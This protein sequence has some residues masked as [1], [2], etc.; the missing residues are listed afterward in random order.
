MK[1]VILGFILGMPFW[2]SSQTIQNVNK[3]NGTSAP[4]NISA[5]D[6]IVFPAGGGQ[7]QIHL[8]NAAPVIHQ[9]QD[10]VNVNFSTAIGGLFPAGSVFCNGTP[11]AIVE[12]TNPTTGRVWM[13][14]N[15]G[16]TQVAVNQFDTNSYGDLYQW[17]RR[18]DGH[19]C[20]NSVITNTLSSS[21]QPAHGDFIGGFNYWLNTPNNNLWQGI[22][23][24]NNPCPSGYRLPTMQELHAERMSWSSQNMLGAFGSPL[25]LP[26]AGYRD[27]NGLLSTSTK[28]QYHSSSLVQSGGNPTSQRLS[29]TF[30]NANNAGWYTSEGL[31]VRCIKHIEGAISDIN[32]G[33]GTNNGLLISGEA[34]LAVGSYIPYSGGN[35]GVHNGQIVVSSGVTGLTAT[36]QAGT[37]AFGSDSLLYVI[38]GTPASS[39]TAT[40]VLNI[41]G[42]SCTLNRNVTTGGG[43]GPIPTYPAGS[44]FCFGAPTAIVDVGSP[45]TGRIWMDRNLGASQSAISSN[46]NNAMGDSYQWGRRSDGHQCVYSNTTTT[47]S[48]SDTPNHGDFIV[49]PSLGF[50]NWR[51]PSNDNLWQGVNGVNNP[52][53]SGYRLPTVAEFYAEYV[54]I[55]I[56]PLNL[57]DFRNSALNSPLKFCRSRNRNRVDGSFNNGA[58]IYWTSTI[59]A[60]F[61]DNSKAFELYYSSGGPSGYASTGRRSSG[62]S[63]RCIK[64]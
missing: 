12:V 38:N 1:K 24:V 3:T 31:S 9:L 46:D 62:Y 50:S 44:V 5:I 6:S 54:S 36:L 17:G 21:V 22:N 48:S 30:T 57:G 40:F 52:C 7:M 32:C 55:P 58:A 64:N 10:I 45:A 63:V 11:T 14:R 13:D 42:Q 59:D 43:S 16:A 56:N 25:K 33:S 41:G 23:G 53:P 18:S 60:T 39:G 28:S 35:G 37:F 4:N 47:Y 2:V 61:I 34:A 51:N 8:N 29:F 19:Q 27:Q 26:F 49:T 15:L 20:R